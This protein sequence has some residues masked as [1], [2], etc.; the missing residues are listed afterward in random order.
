MGRRNGEEGLVKRGSVSIVD[1]IRVPGAEGSCGDIFCGGSGGGGASGGSREL[2]GG[3]LDVCCDSIMDSLREEANVEKV[4]KIARGA[5]SSILG[6]W[7]R[8][9]ASGVCK[10]GGESGQGEGM[11]V[12][13]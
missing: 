9:K 12:P 6:V 2:G 10:G 5:V 11:S 1:C 7:V 8:D 13:F 4:Q 3:K